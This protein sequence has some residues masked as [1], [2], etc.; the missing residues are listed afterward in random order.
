MELLMKNSHESH[1]IG[2][3]KIGSQTPKSEPISD[4]TVNSSNAIR[5]NEAIKD[6]LKRNENERRLG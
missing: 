6:F 1:F 2:K 5:R 3:P 4:D